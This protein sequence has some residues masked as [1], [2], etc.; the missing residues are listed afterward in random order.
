MTFFDLGNT[1]DICT[2]R[3]AERNASSIQQLCRPLLL[4]ALFVRMAVTSG[5]RRVSPKFPASSR[6]EW[7][8][9]PNERARRR[10]VLRIGVNPI[11]GTS[12]RSRAARNVVEPEVV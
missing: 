4:Y 2:P 7:R 12:G 10:A 6:H 11:T 1:Q 5:N 9:T 3:C 8:G